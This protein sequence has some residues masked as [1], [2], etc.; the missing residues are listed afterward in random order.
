VN[1][2]G[3]GDYVRHRRQPTWGLGKIAALVPP[4][5]VRVRFV[6]GGERLLMLDQTML[7]RVEPSAEEANQFMAGGQRSVR[8]Q[9]VPGHRL[10]NPTHRDF[11]IS[12]GAP[13]H[14]V[15]WS[16]GALRQ[17][18]VV[19]LRIWKDQVRVFEG[20]GTFAQVDRVGDVRRSTP[21]AKERADH[22]ARIR[23]GARSLLVMC[24]AEDV[25][26]RP[27]KV[28][29]YERGELYQGERVIERDGMAWIGIGHPVP[30]EEAL[31]QA[32]ALELREPQGKR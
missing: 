11:F 10:R 29:S 17:D 13:L 22:V 31:A 16:W 24:E 4:D 5:K 1:Q 21:G 14:N 15:R 23:Q 27:R 3:V 20:E 28:L 8:Q 19:V 26:A 25:D 9:A 30:I 32:G 18:G 2:L 12:L 7:E 6:P